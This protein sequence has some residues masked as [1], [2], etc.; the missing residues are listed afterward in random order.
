MIFPL[1]QPHDEHDGVYDHKLTTFTRAGIGGLS[2]AASIGC[3]GFQPFYGSMTP[4][5]CDI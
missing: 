1:L 4:M 3:L 2:R 5:I